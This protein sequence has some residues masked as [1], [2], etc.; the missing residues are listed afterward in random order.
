MIIVRAHVAAR[1]R[2]IKAQHQ[3]KND[4]RKTRR[5][6]KKTC[7]TKKKNAPH[8]FANKE[9]IHLFHLFQARR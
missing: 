5:P 6:N 2:R 4:E 1:E 9:G 7:K 3:Q 8:L